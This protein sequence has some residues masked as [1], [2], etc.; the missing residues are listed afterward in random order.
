MELSRAL[1]WL[2]SHINHEATPASG[3]AAGDIEGLSLDPMR[4]FCSALGDPQLS[5]AT[6][7]VTGTNGKGSVVAQIE[8]I[9]GHCGLAVGATT[10]P[11]LSRI[12]ERIRRNGVAIS[13]ADLAEVLTELADIELVVGERLTW[14]E[15]VCAAA[16][17]WFSNVG[18]DAAVVEV[19]LLGRFDATNVIESTVSVITNV[20]KDHTDG[21][22]GWEAR[23]AWEKAGVVTPG[24]DVVVGRLAPELIDLVRAERPGRLLRLG[25]E[26]ELSGT[27]RALGGNVVSV[28]TPW[29]RHEGLFV[30][31]HGRGQVDNA[32]LAV[33]AAEA[34]FDRA[35]DHELLQ[36]AVA[37]TALP[38]RCEV[39]AHR[40]LIV[41]DGAHNADA[42][43]LL[44]E[45]LE[46]ELAVAGARIAVVGMLAGRDPRDVLAALQAFG[47]DL[48]ICTTP[49][50]ARALRSAEL[51]RV[52]GE[53]HL[54]VERRDDPADALALALRTASA[55][56]LVLVTGSFTMLD[57]ARRDVDRHLAERRPRDFPGDE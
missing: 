26:I 2:D 9:L 45:T 5:Y 43:G 13:D 37:S 48:V 54:P 4:R 35:I 40:P 19:G 22:P 50:S 31:A 38:G 3:I 36:S 47:I 57:G 18:V 39:I 10:S 24:S 23:V 46:A 42:V 8:S 52:A 17:S 44:V 21:A 56:D 12:N 53:L 34:F 55:D 25:H 51:A 16:F 1:A 15:L 41:L 30:A 29:A 32:A 20:G 7:H 28:E 14:F 27:R 11:H 33:A 6:I 49:P